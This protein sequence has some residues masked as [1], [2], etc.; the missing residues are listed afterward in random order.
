MNLTDLAIGRTIFAENCEYG[1][2]A[3]SGNLEQLRRIELFDR[4]AE[5][6]LAFVAAH[7]AHHNY[8]AGSQVLSHHD[9][10]NDVFFILSGRLQVKN[11][12][13]SGREFI[14]SEIGA[15]QLFGEFSALDGLPRSAS[16]EAI[17]D[18]LVARMKAT[19]FVALL[20]SD[21]DLTF[22]LLRLLTFKSRGL[23]DRMFELIALTAR[24]RLC[25]ELAR[26]A[27]EGTK[28]GT[29]IMIR[30][31]PTHYEFAARIGSHR[32]AVTRELNQLATRGYLRLGRRHIVI[33]DADRFTREM[34]DGEA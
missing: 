23:S 4:L 33:L 11:Y 26:L 16:V 19:D 9:K 6:R 13:R 7:S 29:S 31:A 18:S 34:L 3:A 1:A 2:V 22:R 30:P 8:S 10:S 27:H 12:S 25:V 14:Y 20:K 5:D 32:E 24:D 28:E 21:F 15:G 17:D